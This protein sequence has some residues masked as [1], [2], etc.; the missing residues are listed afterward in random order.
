MRGHYSKIHK[1][2]CIFIHDK[3]FNN[4]AVTVMEKVEIITTEV[5]GQQVGL[6]V[7]QW[8]GEQVREKIQMFEEEK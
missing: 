1:E 8:Q 4:L 7:E 5:Q 2:R 3:T 6:I